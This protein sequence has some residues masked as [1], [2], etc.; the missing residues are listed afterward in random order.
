[1]VPLRYHKQC[2]HFMNLTCA[3]YDC[4]KTT[5]VK[6]LRKESIITSV[7]C[8]FRKKFLVC[9]NWQFE[10]DPRETVASGHFG[11]SQMA[12]SQHQSTQRKGLLQQQLFGMLSTSQLL[13]KRASSRFDLGAKLHYLL[14]GYIRM[15]GR[16]SPFLI[17][18]PA[19]QRLH[20]DGHRTTRLKKQMP[21]KQLCPI[22]KKRAQSDRLRIIVFNLF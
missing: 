9:R 4:L 21:K 12:T 3:F 6:K 11:N 14:S 20:Q 19:R 8:H 17:S 7:K 1:M 15:K 16:E 18:E 5:N 10:T 2:S 22:N 13:A